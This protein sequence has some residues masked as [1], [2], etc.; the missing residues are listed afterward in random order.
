MRQIVGIVLFPADRLHVG[1]DRRKV[2]RQLL[3]V[4]RRGNHVM[5]QPFKKVEEH[6]VLGQ[7]IEHWNVSSDIKLVSTKHSRCANTCIVGC[8][9]NPASGA[10]AAI[11]RHLSLDLRH[12]CCYN[13]RPSLDEG[14]SR[15]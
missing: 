5:R 7:Q 1:L 15:K 8:N 10:P 2:R 11:C 13:S 12:A 14:V 3:Q 6:C 9:P 4:H